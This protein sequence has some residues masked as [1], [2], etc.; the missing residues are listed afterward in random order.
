MAAFCKFYLPFLFIAMVTAPST[1]ASVA[2]PVASVTFAPVAIPTASF[3]FAPVIIAPVNI[4]SVAIPAASDFATVAAP[5]DA[6][7]KLSV[8]AR[9]ALPVSKKFG[10]AGPNSQKNLIKNTKTYT[11]VIVLGDA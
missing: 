5:G 10:Y 6:S 7:D 1:S 3:A 4:A 8:A 9:V 11:D 2:F